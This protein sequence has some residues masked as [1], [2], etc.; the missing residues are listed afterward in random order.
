MAGILLGGRLADV[1]NPR[2]GRGR[3]YIQAAGLAIAAPFLFLAGSAQ[4]IQFLIAGL[5]V[6][7]VGRGM[8]DCNAMPVLCQIARPELRATG[9]GIFNCAG[10]IA[11]GVM[12]AVAGGLKST[13]GLSASFQI[14]AVI[15]F[16]S[17]IALLRLRLGGE[18][19]IPRSLPAQA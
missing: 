7:G 2:T 10:C 19:A 16:L 9:Y 5:I 8:F 4:S 15:L 6:F 13:L 11:G 3:L 17:A 14:A 18:E 1:L 12:A